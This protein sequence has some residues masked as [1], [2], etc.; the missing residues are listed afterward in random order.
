MRL[1]ARAVLLALLV[2]AGYTA[3][4]AAQSVLYLDSG[5]R[6][7]F[8]FSYDPV[9]RIQRDAT[10]GVVIREVVA[11]SPAERAGLQVGDTILRI[12]DIGAT[13][14]FLSSLGSALSPGDEVRF[15]LRRAGRSRSLTL[16]AA[17]PPADYVGLG[18]QAGLLRI[19]GDSIR[20][21]TRIFVDSAFASIDSLRVPDIVVRRSP[22]NIAFGF[23][24]DS[25]RWRMSSDSARWQFFGDS[26]RWNVLTDSGGVHV[27]SFG[28]DSLWTEL[29]SLRTRMRFRTGPMNFG[30]FSDSLPDRLRSTYVITPDSAVRWSFGNEPFGMTMVGRSAIA[31]AELTRLD[32]AMES[33]FGVAEGVLVVRVPEGTPA[34]DA[35]LRAGDVILRANGTSV[36]DVE[37]LRREIRRARGD[38]V[39]L[40]VTRN[41]RQVT[42]NLRRDDE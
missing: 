19:D 16:T 26:A 38:A 33:Y 13:P 14:Q 3:G 15:E 36:T 7:W 22:G 5:R 41:R 23:G 29:D 10:P 20:A 31:G 27:F 39:R 37:M 42:I 24:G 4:V 11:G 17:K 12:N 9:A 35:G 25:M 1:K 40:D 8:G 18:P 6:A 28:T 21:L 30:F 32:P 2:T 34:A